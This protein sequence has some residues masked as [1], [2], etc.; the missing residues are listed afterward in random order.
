MA[1]VIPN[2]FWYDV[3]RKVISLSADTFYCALV[4]NTYTP[5]KDDTVWSASIDPGSSEIIGSVA[6]G[7]TTGGVALA[8]VVF[9]QDDTNDLCKFDAN[10][11]VWTSSTITARYAVVYDSTPTDK[12]IVAVYEFSADKSSSTGTFTIQWSTSGLMVFEQGT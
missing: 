12:T 9:S 4:D 8:G 3:L 2:R 11:A 6:V 5:N 7:Y 1:S 10:D